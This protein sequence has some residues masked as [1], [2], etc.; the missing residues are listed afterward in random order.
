M[1]CEMTRV[2]YQ[3]PPNPS[4][5]A[6]FKKNASSPYVLILAKKNGSGEKKI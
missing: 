4:K 1:Q 2:Q 5:I 3:H 6:L